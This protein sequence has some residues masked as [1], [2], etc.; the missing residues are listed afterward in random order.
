MLNLCTDNRSMIHCCTSAYL[1]MAAHG[2]ILNT[3]GAITALA[4]LLRGAPAFSN[5]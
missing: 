4:D 3:Y 5:H 2:V 1:A